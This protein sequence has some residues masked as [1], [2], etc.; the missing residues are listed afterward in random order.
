MKE[1]LLVI[2]TKVSPLTHQL[3]RWRSGKIVDYRSESSR[4]E[5]TGQWPALSESQIR[6]YS[7]NSYKNIWVARL[8]KFQ[9]LASKFLC[10]DCGVASPD[11]LPMF[12][13]MMITNTDD[14]RLNFEKIWAW[15][16][17]E[18]L[19]FQKSDA[20]YQCWLSSLCCTE[21]SSNVESKHEIQLKL[22][23]Y[24]MSH[25]YHVLCK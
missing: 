6:P 2:R 9:G 23:V 20:H 24:M 22:N 11:F 4:F 13:P 14:E 3:W 17:S 5:I 12:L 16:L 25:V 1:N 21:D 10:A 8:V 19:N 15:I 18:P 7:L